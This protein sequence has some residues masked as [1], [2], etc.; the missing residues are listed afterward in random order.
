MK[1]PFLKKFDDEFGSEG[2]DFST[3]VQ[4]RSEYYA[5]VAASLQVF[6]EDQIVRMGQH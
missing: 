4:I 6:V 3:D 1:S 5:D 2:I